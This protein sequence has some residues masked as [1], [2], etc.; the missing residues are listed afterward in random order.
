M[1]AI[2]CNECQKDFG[3]FEITTEILGDEVTLN[4]CAPCV[5][6][7]VRPVPADL[8]RA[9]AEWEAEMESLDQE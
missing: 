6:L 2:W 8:E 9:L 5:R 4:L 3:V 1:L 7:K